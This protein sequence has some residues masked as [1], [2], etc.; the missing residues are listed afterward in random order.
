MPLWFPCEMQKIKPVFLGFLFCGILDENAW[1]LYLGSPWTLQ[2]LANSWTLMFYFLLRNFFP[3]VKKTLPGL[4]LSWFVSDSACRQSTLLNNCLLIKH[5][6][7]FLDCTKL[8]LLYGQVQLWSNLHRRLQSRWQKRK[9]E[10]TEG[11][12]I[13]YWT[14]ALNLIRFPV[15]YKPRGYTW[16]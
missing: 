7:S 5:P 9:K 12:F 6:Q 16:G 8:C 3:M 4:A 11:I 2:Q 1:W 14:S 10:L 15:V 13:T